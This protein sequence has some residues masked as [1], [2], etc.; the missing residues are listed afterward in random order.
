MKLLFVEDHKDLL[1]VYEL[2]ISHEL[3]DVPSFFAIS[4]EAALEIIKKENITHV[5]TDAKMPKMS[6]IELTKNISANWPEI[7]VFM[8]SGYAGHYTQEE[9]REIGIE[10][11][12]EKPICFDELIDF[13]KNL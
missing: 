2:E 10:K 1:D 13:I 9:L 11:F 5:F 3:K 6:G 12:F 7:K 4:G 8:I